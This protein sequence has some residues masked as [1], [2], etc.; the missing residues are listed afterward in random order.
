MGSVHGRFMHELCQE[1]KHASES[2]RVHVLISF[3]L[4][5]Y[6]P[7]IRSYSTNKKETHRRVGIQLIIATASV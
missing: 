3:R 4:F 2:A 7:C 5:E 6:G 1:W